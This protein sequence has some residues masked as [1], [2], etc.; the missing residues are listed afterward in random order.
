MERK[1]QYRFSECHKKHYAEYHYAEWRYAECRGARW[2]N[3]EVSC[4]DDNGTLFPDSNGGTV[5]EHLPC[6]LNVKGFSPATGS[7][8]KKTAKRFSLTSSGCCVAEHLSSNPKVMGF[9]PA[10]TTGKRV[11]KMS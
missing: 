1:T 9:S 10:T 5:V 8:T 6:N 11:K 3:Q 4:I 7:V 2:R